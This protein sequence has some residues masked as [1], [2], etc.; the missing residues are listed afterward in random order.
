MGVVFYILHATGNTT[1]LEN[2]RC[3]K[4]ECFGGDMFVFL[5]WQLLQTWKNK[6]A[7]N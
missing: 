4:I 7:I 2:Y 5:L 6:F 1:H 3:G